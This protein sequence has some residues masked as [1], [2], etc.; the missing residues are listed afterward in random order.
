MKS[1]KPAVEKNILLSLNFWFVLYLRF[2]HINWLL[3][4]T[5][6][7]QLFYVQV[8]HY[9]YVIFHLCTSHNYFTSRHLFWVMRSIVRIIL[10]HR[11]MQSTQHFFLWVNRIENTLFRKQLSV[12]SLLTFDVLSCLLY[13]L[14]TYIRWNG[15]QWKWL[16]KEENNASLSTHLQ[17]PIEITLCASIFVVFALPFVYC[18]PRIVIGCV[19]M[20]DLCFHNISGSPRNIF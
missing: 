16:P 19:V 18:S 15:C 17:Q 6:I 20:C 2:T 14:I 11:P 10:P 7:S 13:W 4:H 1:R 8:K 5:S 3:Q 12:R 9:K